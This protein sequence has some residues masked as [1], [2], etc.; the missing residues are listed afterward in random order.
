MMFSNKPIPKKKYATPQLKRVGKL[1][2]LTQKIGSNNDALTST[3][4]FNP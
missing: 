4:S 3:N 1:K 2:A